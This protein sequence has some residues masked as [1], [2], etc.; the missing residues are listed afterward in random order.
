[1]SNSPQANAGQSDRGGSG[2]DVSMVAMIIV[3][4][5]TVVWL[6]LILAGLYAL[7]WA[8]V[9]VGFL[10]GVVVA[11]GAAMKGKNDSD[12]AHRASNQ[13]ETATGGSIPNLDDVLRQ[14][15]HD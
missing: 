4:V 2:R 14:H 1:M 11:L 9:G 7:A 13:R 10:F 3:C 15:D 12:D 6:I 8:W 5:G